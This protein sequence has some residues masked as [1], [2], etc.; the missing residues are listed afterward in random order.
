MNNLSYT[1]NPS[2]FLSS[3]KALP[4]FQVTYLKDLLL[5]KSAAVYNDDI[6][7]SITETLARNYINL[8]SKTCPHC[9]SNH[10]IRNGLNSL[11]L[12][13]YKCKDCSKI[14]SSKTNTP[15]SYSKKPIQ[16]W[17]EY[18]KCMCEKLTL[19]EAADRLKIHRNTAFYWR[20][21]ILKALKATLNDKL[22]GIVEID[23]LYINESFKGNHSK[24][25]NFS[26]NREPIKR[27]LYGYKN[28]NQPKICILCCKDRA[29]NI[30]SQGACRGKI[31]YIHLKDILT[32][33]IPKKSILCANHKLFYVNFA[34]QIK[35][36]L[37]R[38]SNNINSKESPYNLN[39][40]KTFS[41]ELKKFIN[42]FNGVA[43][44]YINFYISWFKWF[45]LSE[46]EKIP[47]G[48]LNLFL[49]VACSGE[50]LRIKDFKDV[51][52]IA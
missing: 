11:K 3:I 10:I 38:I 31:N 50:S 29:D 27:K 26:M 30:L 8:N 18:L 12:Q 42:S 23:E 28:L 43:T 17:I 22:Q 33:K 7:K 20:H 5:N 41:F 21:K 45:K 9:S 6:T 36:K 13:R 49:L 24:K 48:L 4:P 40:V 1:L 39:N 19:R 46:V 16:K 14:F 35:S 25:L 32:D 2:E 47:R 51:K 15:M 34:K 52:S 44:K 37:Y